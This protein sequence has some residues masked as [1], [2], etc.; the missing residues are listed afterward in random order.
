ML[1]VASGVPWSGRG[2]L[3]D[4]KRGVHGTVGNGDGLLNPDVLASDT[5]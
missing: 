5:V 2:S 4:A 1:D 3:R